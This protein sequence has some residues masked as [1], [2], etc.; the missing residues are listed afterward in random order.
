MSNFNHSIKVPKLYKC[1]A[2]ICQEVAGGGGSIKHL[3]YEKKHFNTKA[4]YALVVTTFQRAQEIDLLLKRTK[5]F[6]KEPRLE[7]WLAKVFISELMWGK[8]ILPK[9]EAKPVQTILAYEQAF[10]AHLSDSSVNH[11]EGNIIVKKPRYVRINT[12][13]TSFN[14]SLELFQEEGWVLQQIKDHQNYDSFIEQVSLLEGD[15]FLRDIHISDLLIFPHGTQFYNH[16]GYKQGAIILQD[17]ASCIPVH[18]LSPPPGSIILDMCAA[19]GMKTTQLAALMKDEGTIYAVERDPKRFDVLNKIVETSGSK[20][21]KAIN[22]DV[23]ECNSSDF[24]DVEYI[25]VDPSCSGSG[26][27][28]RVE[29][30]LSKNNARLEKLAGFQIKI[31]RSALTRYPNVKKVVYSTCSL[32]PEENEDVVRQVL[33]T[34]NEFRLVPADT[35]INKTWK[36]FG[37][38]DFGDIGKFCLYAK[39]EEDLTNGFFVAVLERC[40]EGEYNQFFNGR[41]LKYMKKHERNEKRKKERHLEQ[42]KEN[43]DEAKVSTELVNLDESEGRK[44]KK[45]KKK[46]NSENIGEINENIDEIEDSTELVNQNGN[47][48][49]KFKKK[50][51]KEKLEKNLDHINENIEERKDSTELVNQNETEGIKIKKKKKDKNSNQETLYETTEETLEQEQLELNLNQKKKK[52]KK[53]KEQQQNTDDVEITEINIK[54][55]KNEKNIDTEK[56][57]KNKRK[58]EVEITDAFVTTKKKKNHKSKDIN[59]E[60]EV[61]AED[62]F[63]GDKLKKKKRKVDKLDSLNDTDYSSKMN[64]DNNESLKKKKKV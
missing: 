16:P 46:D 32:Y 7:P 63:L 17:K 20:C 22:K 34:N 55:D 58:N 56:V 28:D 26:M 11:I 60:N 49:I 31:L 45:K 33:E 21:I 8:K 15:L 42:T 43:I 47:E 51:K 37:S 27:V 29:M 59:V 13:L 52:N 53:H 18:I 14:E 23:L 1:A 64:N 9:S 19:P 36:N 2:K 40:K 50:K 3:I 48:G 35:F 61:V 6:E 38:P 44:I 39:P 5:L 12:L 62:N 54:E 41:S 24:P 4:L 57:S 30:T 10:K 25:L